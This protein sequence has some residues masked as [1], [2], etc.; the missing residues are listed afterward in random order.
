MK[1]NFS[2][3]HLPLEVNAAKVL[4]RCEIFLERKQVNELWI[5][6]EKLWKV[7][8]GA[9][10]WELNRKL[11][12]NQSHACRIFWNTIITEAWHQA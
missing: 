4:A 11:N 10:F 2:P 12:S 1:F 6:V 7:I 3:S 8:E 5:A 9:G